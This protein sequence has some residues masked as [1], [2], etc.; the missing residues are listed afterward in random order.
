MPRGKTEAYVIL[1]IRDDVPK[2]YISAGFQRPPSRA[3]LKQWIEQQNIDAIEQCFDKI[4]VQVGDVFLIPGGWPNALGEGILMLEI[5]EP[6]DLAVRF[7]FERCG[8]I[9]PEAARFMKRDIDT[10]LDVF[11]FQPVLT[12]QVDVEFCC[13]PQKLVSDEQNNLLEKLIGSEHTPFFSIKRAQV[14]GLFSRTNE[15][16]FY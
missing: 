15:A 16:F 9:I 7:E 2:P 10:A 11:N 4:P 3:Q 13:T 12:D 8:Y 6:S 1:A 5:I 14:N